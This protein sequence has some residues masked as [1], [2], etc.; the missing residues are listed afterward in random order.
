MVILSKKT[1]IKL[2]LLISTVQGQQRLEVEINDSDVIFRA[3]SIRTDVALHQTRL[4]PS[5][6]SNAVQSLIGAGQV[7][8]YE[9]DRLVREL[10]PL[11]G[12]RA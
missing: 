3:C 8:D 1:S 7:Y 4:Y 6:M 10:I 12:D 11:I 2:S 5:R 9:L